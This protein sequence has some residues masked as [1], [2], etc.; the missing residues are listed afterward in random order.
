MCVCISTQIKP[1]QEWSQVK[2]LQQSGKIRHDYL[3][4]NPIDA[5]VGTSCL[6]KISQAAA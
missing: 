4:K 3:E 6:Q 2:A 1:I 5:K